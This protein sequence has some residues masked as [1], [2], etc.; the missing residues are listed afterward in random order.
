[1]APPA[2]PPPPAR[3]YFGFGK[4]DWLEAYYARMSKASA[5][6][7]GAAVGSAVSGCLLLCCMCAGFRC[8]WAKYGRVKLRMY[9]REHRHIR[10]V[11]APLT[12]RGRR[13]SRPGRAGTSSLLQQ[14]EAAR[15]RGRHST[16]RQA[17]ARS[18]EEHD[19]DDEL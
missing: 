18:S 3:P 8:W 15:S 2:A 10:I 11:T 6:L 4:L 7:A 17:T 16:A 19:G 1:M 5:T 9:E 12:A 13:A 14:L